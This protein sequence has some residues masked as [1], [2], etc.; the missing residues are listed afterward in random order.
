MMWIWLEDS[1]MSVTTLDCRMFRMLPGYLTAA[2][3]GMLSLNCSFLDEED[4][5]HVDRLAHEFVDGAAVAEGD[6][7]IEVLV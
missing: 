7:L 3:A 5:E 6:V 2:E 4:I 1:G